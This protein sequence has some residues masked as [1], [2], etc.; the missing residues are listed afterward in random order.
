MAGYLARRIFTTNKPF[1]IFHS[2]VV[3]DELIAQAINLHKSIDLDINIDKNNCPFFG[4]SDYFYQKSGELKEINTQFDKLLKVLSQ[5]NI[6]VMLDCKH[7]GAWPFV[8]KAL[9]L[10]GPQRCFVGCMATEFKFDYD[11]SYDFEV[12]FEYSSISNLKILKARYPDVTTVASC[13]FLPT[14]FLTAR[15]YKVLRNKIRSLLIENNVDSLSLNFPYTSY[16][17]KDLNFFLEANILLELKVEDISPLSVSEIY[18]GE[19]DTLQK[20][21][22]YREIVGHW[23][24]DVRTCFSLTSSIRFSS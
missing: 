5:S 1:I 4:H 17:D 24:D 21:T 20:V 11:F 22:D 2:H 18:L 6:P 23:L 9:S 12:P 3:N 10:L 19:T 14:D 13:S 16:S 7:C 15:K 8:E